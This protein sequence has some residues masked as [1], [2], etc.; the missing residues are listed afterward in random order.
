MS[1]NSNGGNR[2]ALAKKRTNLKIK[3]IKESG[4]AYLA[5]LPVLVL[6]GL[7]YVIPIIQ[8]VMFS[9]TNYSIKHF[10][11]YTSVGL[12]NYEYVFSENIDGLLGLAAWTFVFAICVVVISFIIATLLASILNNNN[13]KLR[14]LYRTLFII[15]WVIPSVITLLM[16]RG[17]LNTSN[18][19]VN[20]LLQSA[21]L[22]PVPW[23]T[24]PTMARISVILV[25]VWCSF[26]FLSVVVLGQLQSIPKTLYEA[27]K[28]DGATRF[29][30][31][32]HITLPHII[33]GM[34]PVLILTFIMQFNNFG[35]YLVTEGGPAS[36]KLGAPGSTDIL[37]TY[38][39][40]L[41]FKVYRYD[42]AATY[43]VV[44]FVFLAIFALI[45]M[46][47]SKK[48]TKE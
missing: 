48:I 24:D 17:L 34:S 40:N 22:N 13:I 5:L 9:F 29:Q 36:Q 20:A 1:I 10:K 39:Y 8:N 2:S 4:S 28:I 37:L 42:Y 26:P 46:R 21:G 27:T 35:V 7:F 31:F 38:V 45:S 41:A 12:D 30:S 19:F 33:R 11:D 15:P 44:I 18:G 6:I 43:S 23:L 32:M 14:K 47:A 3:R 16:W 25:V